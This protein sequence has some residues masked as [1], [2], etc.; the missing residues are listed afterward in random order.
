MNDLLHEVSEKN[1]NGIYKKE[2]GVSIEKKFI[3]TKSASSDVKSQK[4]VYPKQFAFNSNTS[5]NSDTLS[6]AYNN[7]EP[8]IISNTYVTFNCNEKELLSEYLFM[9][10]KRKEFD[11]FARYNSWGSARE[12]ISL[13]E[14]KEYE[15]SIPSIEVQQS[16]INIQ[17]AY[18]K[19][20]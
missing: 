5:R 7:E 14:I 3:N 15:I 17:R 10:F 4:V 18:L 20:K 2:K 13:N 16:I 1:V 9:W 6:I 12:T 11:R 19:R 8:Y